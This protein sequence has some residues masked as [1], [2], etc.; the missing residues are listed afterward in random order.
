[1][2]A[3]T[4][5]WKRR[6]ALAG[7]AWLTVAGMS[8][9]A[10]DPQPI[11]VESSAQTHVAHTPRKWRFWGK[12]SE[13]YHP[14][15][16]VIE[17][18][19]HPAPATTTTPKMSG[20]DGGTPSTG[21]SGSASSSPNVE[22]NAGQVNDSQA[23]PDLGETGGGEAS[24]LGNPV[25]SSYI[26]SAIPRTQLRIRGDAAYDN[27]RPDRA[28]FFYSKCGCNPGAPGPFWIEKRV[29]YQDV[30]A[31]LEYAPRNNFSVFAEVPFRFLNPESNLNEEGISNCNA[32]FKYAFIADECRYLTAQFRWNFPIWNSHK[33]LGYKHQAIE[34]SLL[35][36]QKLSD[37]LFVQ[38]ELR[39]WIPFA[40]TD[41]Q[42]NVL[43][44]GAGVGF[45]AVDGC[46]F[47]AGP[48]AEVVGWTVLSGKESAVAGD[49][50]TPTGITTD[51]AEGDTIVNGKL[52]V[53]MGFGDRT[54]DGLLNQSDVFVGYS[55]ALTGE[56]WYKDM[57]RVELRLRF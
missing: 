33:G 10:G 40:G 25:E 32:G 5:L 27:N 7:L 53:R 52:G 29:D 1:M 9:Q 31:Y 11:V 17:S 49:N 43:R 19:P 51:S 45:L 35:Y 6:L 38:G 28:E 48:I 44:Y 39:D 41:F 42:G 2:F 20:A 34:T 30:S 18:H 57:Y 46:R 56:V 14:A 50:D 47:R 24:S 54:Q 21:G 15:P 23:G 55:R 8:G 36:Y 12:K 3:F 26:D 16:V 4:G 13:E 37:R 22:G